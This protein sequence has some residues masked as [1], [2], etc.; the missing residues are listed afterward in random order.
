MFLLQVPN[1][2]VESMCMN[3]RMNDASKG[4][5]NDIDGT[6]LEGL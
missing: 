2:V 1:I 4:K 5:K 6:W 3:R